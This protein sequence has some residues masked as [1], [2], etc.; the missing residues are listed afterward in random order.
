MFTKHLADNFKTWPEASLTG[1]LLGVALAAAII[2]LWPGRP[3]LKAIVLAWL[4][5][6]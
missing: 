3:V 2:A 6:P 1:A 4:V 5:F